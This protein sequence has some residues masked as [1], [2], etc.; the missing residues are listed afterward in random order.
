LGVV[1]IACAPKRIDLPNDPGTPLPD[2]AQ[3]HQQVTAA[4]GGVRSMTAELGLSGRAGDQRLRGTVHAGLVRPSS[5]RLE[6]VAAGQVFFI[7]AAS[8]DNAVLYRPR[9]QQV[10]RNERPEAILSALTGIDLAPADL[11]AILTGCVVPDGGVPK[12]GRVHRGGLAAIDLVGATIYL[13]RV[14]GAWQLRA[15]R[16]GPWRIDYP[17]WQGPFP[18]AV[19]MLSSQPDAPVDLTAA[20]GQLE[21][22]A[23]LGAEAF[24]VNVPP[25]T[26]PM[27]LDELRRAG[28]FRGQ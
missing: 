8:N 18:S 21:T 10:L 24:T 3:I 17:T 26:D 6:A 11:L 22:A 5:M 2:F 4:C 1:V 9:E 20:I 27:T 7:L 28:P 25:G 16:R 23:A 13:Q 15:A 12:A 14:G 19:R